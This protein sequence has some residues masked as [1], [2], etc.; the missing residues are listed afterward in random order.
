MMQIPAVVSADTWA[1]RIKTQ[2]SSLHR[3]STPTLYQ[4]LLQICFIQ[5]IVPYQKSKSA[6][7]SLEP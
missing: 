4:S 6:F 7:D 3:Y 5:E 2:F 1:A